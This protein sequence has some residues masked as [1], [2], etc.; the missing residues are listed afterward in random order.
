[1]ITHHDEVLSLKPENSIG[2]EAIRGNKKNSRRSDDEKLRPPRD[3]AAVSNT[4]GRSKRPRHTPSRYDPNQPTQLGLGLYQPNAWSKHGTD[5]EYIIQLYNDRLSKEKW[6]KSSGMRYNSDDSSLLKFIPG[7]LSKL[8]ISYVLAM[9]TKGVHYA[10]G[11]DGLSQ[12]IKKYGDSHNPVLLKYKSPAPVNKNIPKVDALADILVDIGCSDNE[13][14]A[15][16]APT[17]LIDNE[18]G[19]VVVSV[20]DLGN[21]GNQ[22]ICA[23]CQD[24]GE[25]VCC[26]GCPDVYHPACLPVGPSKDSFERN[27]D[28]WYCPKCIPLS[29]HVSS[30]TNKGKLHHKTSNELSCLK[31]LDGNLRQVNG[32]L[33]GLSKGSTMKTHPI[34]EKPVIVTPDTVDETKKCVSVA[35]SIQPNTSLTKTNL[36]FLEEKSLSKNVRMPKSDSPNQPN[37]QSSGSLMGDK[38]NAIIS[39]KNLSEDPVSVASQRS[40]RQSKARVLFNPNESTKVGLGLLQPGTRAKSVLDEKVINAMTLYN[41]HLAKKW[42]TIVRKSSLADEDGKQTYYIP[43]SLGKFRKN[44]VLQKGTRGIHYAAG[45]DGLSLMLETFG[46]DY[47]PQ[48]CS[49]SLLNFGY[50]VEKDLEDI[51]MEMENGGYNACI[52]KMCKNKSSEMP[53]KISIKKSQI[54]PK[55]HGDLFNKKKQSFSKTGAK[56]KICNFT[57]TSM[58]LSNNLRNQCLNLKASDSDV[59]IEKSQNPSS[60]L[61]KHNASLKKVPISTK[62]HS[63]TI[64]KVK[65]KSSFEE[66]PSKTSCSPESLN[67]QKQH[68]YSNADGF[69]SEKIEK[70]PLNYSSG[71]CDNSQK[72][73]LISKERDGLIDVKTSSLSKIEK[74]TSTQSFTTEAKTVSLH[75]VT[76][77][78][79]EQVGID[80]KKGKDKTE[81][82]VNMPNNMRT[83]HLTSELSSFNCVDVNKSESNNPSS[84]I[85]TTNQEQKSESNNLSSKIP[86]KKQEQ[87]SESN[88]PSSK[89]PTKNQEQRAPQIGTDGARNTS[90]ALTATTK[91]KEER[92][93]K[94]IQ[95][96]LATPKSFE[97]NRSN[98]DR[99][100]SKVNVAAI[101]GYSARTTIAKKKRPIENVCLGESKSN[102]SLKEG[103]IST[104]Y[105]DDVTDEK[106]MSSLEEESGYKQARVIDARPVSLHKKDNFLSKPENIYEKKKNS[107]FNLPES[108]Q[109]ITHTLQ[110]QRLPSESSG[111][112]CVGVKK[113]PLNNPSSRYDNSQKRMSISM[114]RHDDLVDEK[115]LSSSKMGVES[116]QYLSMAK[117]VLLHQNKN[118]PSEPITIGKVEE[119]DS[120]NL[121][122]GLML[123]INKSSLLKKSLITTGC[124]N[125][126]IPGKGPSSKIE[127]GLKQY[128]GSDAVS[129]RK[130]SLIT[131]GCFNNLIPGKRP[132]SKI[133]AKPKQ[134]F[135]NDAVSSTKKLLLS[136]ESLDNLINNVPKIRGVI[137]YFATN[138]VGDLQAFATDGKP[139]SLHKNKNSL[140][141]IEAINKG[142][143]RYTLDFPGGHTLPVNKL[144]SF[145]KLLMST[146]LLD[147]STHEK[148]LSSSKIGGPMQFC[149]ADTRPATRHKTDNS[150]LRP[151]TLNSEK[152]DSLNLSQVRTLPVNKFNLLISTEQKGLSF[153]KKGGPMQYCATDTRPVTLHTK[154]NSFLKLETLNSKKIDSLNLSQVRTLSVKKSNLLISTERLDDLIEKKNPP[155]LKTRGGPKQTFAADAGSVSLPQKDNSVPVSEMINKRKKK[156]SPNFSVGGVLPAAKSLTPPNLHQKIGLNAAEHFS[157]SRHS[158]STGSG[159]NSSHKQQKLLNDLRMNGVWK[160]EITFKYPPTSSSISAKKLPPKIPPMQPLQKKKEYPRLPCAV[161]LR[162]HAQ[163]VLDR[164]LLKSKTNLLGKGKT[165]SNLIRENPDISSNESSFSLK[166]GKTVFKEGKYFFE[167]EKSKLSSHES[168]VKK[169]LSSESK[170]CFELPRSS[171]QKEKKSLSTSQ[172]N[173][174]NALASF[175]RGNGKNIGSQVAKLVTNLVVADLNEPGLPTPKCTPQAPPVSIALACAEGDRGKA[176]PLQPRTSEGIAPLPPPLLQQAPLLQQEVRLRMENLKIEHTFITQNGN[177]QRQNLLLERLR[178]LISLRDCYPGGDLKRQKLEKAITELEK[179]VDL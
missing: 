73:L 100:G 81:T 159:A 114:E 165:S 107:F 95:E 112:K 123:P 110:K 67:L 68:L 64:N 57:E 21:D 33:F 143:K 7:S 84:K 106:G 37:S 146:E 102:S 63:G 127:A 115:G 50:P 124:F 155:L 156:D 79:S 27:D 158:F 48:L 29:E 2:S 177:L 34:V 40:R 59:E 5:A 89:I 16:P 92:H 173:G 132:S 150:L 69:E 103:S 44:E 162:P 169:N 113:R 152:I 111:I 122:K 49:Q 6:R 65:E 56:P 97:N 178:A 75:K 157:N 4:V 32:K 142:G 120:K 101:S 130:E 149:A 25:I 22:Y 108:Q 175:G 104:K 53:V 41:N 109:N 39:K 15:S 153:S 98:D 55:H 94:S 24:V 138:A 117:P 52:D 46:K 19:H 10:E 96:H 26:D 161:E 12:M 35:A 137:E 166:P 54:S 171:T 85:P 121:S 176:V 17:P 30:P 38:K 139:V 116:L 82:K 134:Y 78:S 86:T 51:V 136:T 74:N 93:R 31:S 11:W 119:T 172:E 129:S 80:N 3:D 179:M 23:Q 45:W 60:F 36:I 88:N 140:P 135:G 99:L 144:S 167:G 164:G 91:E 28:P 43:G 66:S 1:M 160:G 62:C 47:S 83:Q 170:N 145:K 76:N 126:L 90:P 154:D 147:D 131:T 125:N 18:D 128:F 77:V 8:S 141:E 118:F 151:E 14:C 133:E 87:K 72:K 9:G 58:D 20:G 163:H 148:G 42:R 168:Y 174:A 13:E 70:V 105:Y 71:K 61:K